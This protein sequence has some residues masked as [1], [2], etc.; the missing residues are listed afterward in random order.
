MLSKWIV[1]TGTVKTFL[2]ILSTARK[3]TRYSSV[4]KRWQRFEGQERIGGLPLLAPVV[5][6]SANYYDDYVEFLG[7]K[8]IPDDA[9]NRLSGKCPVTVKDILGGCKGHWDG[10]LT[11]CLFDVLATRF[12]H[13]ACIMMIKLP[14][15]FKRKE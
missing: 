15:R 6:S 10:K 12:N 14:A 2:I 3:L 4:V 8:Y 13:S 5:L 9:T 11:A 1:L 7:K